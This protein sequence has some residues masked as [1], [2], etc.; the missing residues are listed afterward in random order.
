MLAD[1]HKAA[2]RTEWLTT[3]NT[4]HKEEIEEIGTSNPKKITRWVANKDGEETPSAQA[5]PIHG[6]NQF[7]PQGDN[8]NELKTQQKKVS[9]TLSNNACV[10]TGTAAQ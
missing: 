10:C 9:C 1:R 3:P 5:T 6:A 2:Q 8:P 4:Y 7:A